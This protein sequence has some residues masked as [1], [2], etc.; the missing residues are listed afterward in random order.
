MST[1]VSRPA[2]TPDLTAEEL[3]RGYW[4]RVELAGFARSL[5][6]PSGGAKADLTERIAA[7]LGG[8]TPPAPVP[9]RHR[10]GPL[11]E[12]LTAAT[13]VPADQRCT[14]QIRRWLL[15]VVG[16]GF[17]F[18]GPMRAFFADGD[19]SRTLGDAVAHWHHSRS[20]AARP[21]D[22]QFELNRFARQW[23]LDH[24]DGSRAEMLAAW[25]HYRALP[26]DRR[27]EVRR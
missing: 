21:I 22:P 16:P 3:G 24:P 10:H 19:G 25:A 4:L 6:L 5:G 9:A 14:Q 27:A 7:H 26:L 12:P 13:V 1:D 20:R 23:H 2:L 18:D 11:P 15:D 17:R 8:T